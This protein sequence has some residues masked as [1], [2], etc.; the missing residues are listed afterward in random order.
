MIKKRET[1][2]YCGEKMES[3]TAKKKFC[4][5]KCKVYYGRELKRGTL[6]MPKVGDVAVNGIVTEGKQHNH[7]LTV[8]INP[9]QNKEVIPKGLSLSEQLE[10]KINH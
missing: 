2:L 4:S 7:S 1:C 9:A 5:A 3:V 10:W 6:D 8:T